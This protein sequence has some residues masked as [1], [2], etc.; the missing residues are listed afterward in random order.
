MNVLGYLIHSHIPTQLRA[1]PFIVRVTISTSIGIHGALRAGIPIQ[2]LDQVDI[3]FLCFLAF[4]LCLF[5]VLILLCLLFLDILL[6]FF[7]FR[8]IFITLPLNVTVT[9]R[10]SR[11]TLTS[12]LHPLRTTNTTLLLIHFLPTLLFCSTTRATRLSL[13]PLP[14]LNLRINI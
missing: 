4:L 7:R 3:V 12:R 1:R 13:L 6:F 2:I 8:L 5:L 14:R 11:F 10:L 9:L